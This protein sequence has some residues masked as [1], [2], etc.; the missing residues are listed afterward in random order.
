MLNE[1]LFQLRTM[2]Q[3]ISDLLQQKLGVFVAEIPSGTIYKCRKDCS[4]CN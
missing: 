1:P 2:L 4:V 3:L